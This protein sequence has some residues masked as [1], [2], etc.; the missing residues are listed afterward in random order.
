MNIRTYA[1]V[2]EN[3]SDRASKRTHTYTQRYIVKH[4]HTYMCSHPRE[5]LSASDATVK[6]S[7]HKYIHT[8]AHTHIH[9]HAH[10]HTTTY[11]HTYTYTHTYIHTYTYTHTYI[12]TY[13]H[14]HIH[15]HTSSL[16]CFGVVHQRKNRTKVVDSL[17]GRHLPTLLCRQSNIWTRKCDEKTDNM[18]GPVLVYS[19]VCLCAIYTHKTRISVC[20]DPYILASCSSLYLISKNP[21]AFSSKNVTYQ[22]QFQKEKRPEEK[23]H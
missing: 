15:T 20:M 1:V 9:T 14:I 17:F 18:S 13:I 11:I 2:Y 8:Y 23:G 3:F 6:R 4:K 10:A 22:T 16:S 19:H 7:F 5:K 12:Y 21:T